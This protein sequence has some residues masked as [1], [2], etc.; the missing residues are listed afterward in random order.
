MRVR[1]EGISLERP[2]PW[3]Q[4]RSCEPNSVAPFPVTTS[5]MGETLVQL[6]VTGSVPSSRILLIWFRA[7]GSRRRLLVNHTSCVA[8]I[9]T[10]ASCAKG[11]LSP[12]SSAS[13][14]AITLR[15]GFGPRIERK[16]GWMTTKGLARES[17]KGR[18]EE[19]DAV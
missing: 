11:L 4:K 5:G 10:P 7:C 15:E 9:Q 12:P 16:E 13:L 8:S 1:E 17:G 2:T 18:D 14:E 19:G 6:L 3:E